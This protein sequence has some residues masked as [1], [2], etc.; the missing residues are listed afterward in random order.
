[1]L[2]TPEHVRRYYKWPTDGQESPLPTTP[3][4]DLARLKLLEVTLIHYARRL[5]LADLRS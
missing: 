4:V 5:D 3:R 1:M 2:L